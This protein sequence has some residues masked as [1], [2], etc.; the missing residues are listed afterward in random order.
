MKS[1][2][3]IALVLLL[4]SCSQKEN[5]AQKIS[6]DTIVKADKTG[7]PKENH[8]KIVVDFDENKLILEILAKLP[9]SVFSSWEWTKKD[10]GDM[11]QSIRKK[12]FYIDKDNFYNNIQTLNPHYLLTQVVD[13]SWNLWLSKISDNSYLVITDDV[14]NDGDEIYFFE[15]KNKE[16]NAL[17]RQLYFN[18]FIDA[19]KSQSKNNECQNLVAENLQLLDFDFSK[20]NIITI[21]VDFL[22]DEKDKKCFNKTN[23]AFGFNSKTKSFTLE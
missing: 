20:E 5:S 23:F 17:E 14:V 6:S 18:E 2:I 19:I 21:N 15:Y 7:N 3:A 13:G 12:G 1:Y 10:R 9:D 16:L 4:F 22:T 8:K 11:V